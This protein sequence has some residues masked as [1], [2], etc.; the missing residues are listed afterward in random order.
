MGI[1]TV[2]LAQGV[3][4]GTITLGEGN[5]FEVPGLGTLT[6]GKD[7]LIITGNLDTFNAD[8]INDYD[9]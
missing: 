9:F 6:F 3:K 2:Y 1:A 5:S 4:D 8:N 7:N